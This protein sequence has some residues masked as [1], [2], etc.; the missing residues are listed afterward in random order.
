L[1]KI[2]AIFL[3]C[4]LTLLAPGQAYVHAAR[5]V[6]PKVSGAGAARGFPVGGNVAGASLT[7][8]QLLSPNL[9]V[10]LTSVL[11][12]AAV[13][14]AFAPNLS[15]PV[16]SS[17]LRNAPAATSLAPL[18]P[19]AALTSGQPGA[20]ALTAV[21]GG[22]ARNSTALTPRKFTTPARQPRR[23]AVLLRGLNLPSVV[24]KGAL[25]SSAGAKD[26]GAQD[27]ARRMGGNYQSQ[28]TASPVARQA[29]ISGAAS[30]NGL[31][32]YAAV[33]PQ[34]LGLQATRLDALPG[35]R[36]GDL[37][38]HIPDAAPLT[39][40]INAVIPGDRVAATSVESLSSPYPQAT[41]RAKPSS[42]WA[43]ILRSLG[44]AGTAVGGLFKAH[45]QPVFD[46]VADYRD[47]Q[48]VTEAPKDAEHSSLYFPLV[49]LG[50]SA[51]LMGL[52]VGV[53]LLFEYVLPSVLSQS[54]MDTVIG[55]PGAGVIAAMASGAFWGLAAVTIFSGLY[56]LWELFAF[57][58]GII[59]KDAPSDDEFWSFLQKELRA[60]NLHPSVYTS[61]LGTGPGRGLL[62]IYRP[63]SK[64]GKFSFA[65]TSNGAV[66][67]RPELIRTP[68]LL[69]MVLKHEFVHL[70]AHLKRGPPQRT[71]LRGILGFFTGEL[72][73]R[74]GPLRTQKTLENMR[75]P[76]LSRVLHEAHFSLNL[77]REYDVL[78]LK[79]G[80]H[81]TR[82]PSIYK[83]LS[84]EQATIDYLPE[85]QDL[86]SYLGQKDNQ[87]RFRVV[88]YPQAFDALP[89]RGTTEARRLRLALLRLDK[90][91]R[92]ARQ[93]PF[94]ERNRT[95]GTSPEMGQI[96]EL[97]ARLGVKLKANMSTEQLEQLIE[98]MFFRVSRESLA[99]IPFVSEL[100]RLY[101][102]LHHK[103]A[104]MMPF[105]PEEPGLDVIERVMR[106]WQSADGGGFAVQRVDLPEGGHILVARK[107]EP[108]V[109][110]WLR[111]AA[112]HEIAT[113]RTNV[114][115]RCEGGS[116]AVNVLR[117]AGFTDS[118]LERFVDADMEVRHI[119]GNDVGD[120]R[121]YV[122]VKRSRAKALRS[123]AQESGIKFQS[124]RAGYEL[125]LIKTAKMHS[126]Q[127]AWRLQITGE[128]G[129]IYDIDTG[130]D[131]EHPDFADR[132]L[133][134]VDFVNE[135]PEDWVGHGTHKGGI[136]YANG[137]IYRG[138][139]PG[140]EGRMGKVFAQTGAGASDGDIMA[141]AVDAMQW[142]ADVISLSLGSPGAVDSPLAQF[143]SR[144]TRQ[145]NSKGEYPIV[146]G[147]AG[148][149][150][151][152][153]QSKSQPSVGEYVASIAAANKAGVVSFFSSVGPALDRRWGRKRYRRPF[154]ATAVGGDVT[155][156][157]DML[158]RPPEKRDVYEGGVEAPKSRNMAPSPSDTADGKHTRM[159]GTSMSNPVYA[160][161]A[162]LVKQAVQRVVKTGSEAHEFFMQHLPDA[163][164]LILM[165]SSEDMR[166][167]LYFQ[168][169][170]FINAE[171]AI[172]MGARTFGGRLMNWRQRAWSWLTFWRGWFSRASEDGKPWE[173]IG[174]A[175]AVWAL[176][177]RV[178]Q[179]AE[180]ARAKRIAELEAN[181]TDGPQDAPAEHP[182]QYRAAKREMG[183]AA[184][185]AL[186][187]RF[188]AVRTE[189]TPE[190]TAT[191]AFAE[192]G[193]PVEPVWLV[194]MYAAWA[195]LNLKTP[196]AILPLAETALND[197]DGR[198]RQAA[199]LAIAET[200]S[201]GA[202]TALRQALT[203]AR[204]DVRMYAGYALAR[205]G[206]ASGVPAILA[207]TKSFDERIRHTAVWLL[208]QLGRRAP[209]EATDSLSSRVMDEEEQGNIRHLGV[210]SLTEI[211]AAQP[212]SVTNETILQLLH[213]AGPRNFAL[214][215][216]IS[217]FFRQAAGSAEIRSRM[218]EKPLRDDIRSF[219]EKYKSS[220]LRPGAL[221]D[222]V[223]IFA[224]VL[225]VPLDQPTPLPNPE[226]VGIV[227]VDP[228]LGPVHMIV[229]VPAVEEGGP[230]IQRYQDFRSAQG[231]AE[232]TQSLASF[233]LNADMI[234]RHEA[235]LQVAMPSSQALWFNVPDHKVTAFRT[236]MES[237]GYVVRRAGP[238][239]RLVHETGPLT[240]MPAVR[241]ELGLTGKN[242]TVAYLDEGGAT[243]HPAIAA[244]RIKG[245]KNFSGDG[246]ADQVDKEAV[247]HGTHGMGIVGGA[248]F[249]GKDGPSPY[250]GMAPEVDFLIG[251]VMGETG[252]SEATVMAGMEWAAAQIEDP[253]KTPLILNM[254]LGGPGSPDSPLGRLAN[255][256]RLNN[257]AVI[258]AAGNAGPRE[259]TVSSPANAALATAIGAVDKA[260][261]LTEYSSRSPSGVQEVNRVNYGGAVNFDIPNMYEIVSALNPRLSDAMAEQPTGIKFDG[262]MLFHTMSGTSMAAPHETGH[263]ALF[264]ERMMQV[265]ET[266]PDGYDLWLDGLL[267]RTAEK[268]DHP[269]NEVG[270]GRTDP[271]AALAALNKALEAPDTI[272]TE[273]AAL[274]AQ[275]VTQH[276]NPAGPA[277]PSPGRFRR[278]HS[279]LPG[280]LHSW[281]VAI[282]S[283]GLYPW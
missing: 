231:R 160:G 163:V 227:G 263:R 122:N 29:A 119:F 253:L 148:N 140:A 179:E 19:V 229:E 257:I 110:L 3:T 90:V 53:P 10:S 188:N 239:Y 166:V 87:R 223:R 54:T 162:L 72:G 102:S 121:I 220:V 20:A 51:G 180:V 137:T 189:V 278:L 94:L 142:G 18:V 221:G 204:A 129:R 79:P 80:S 177:D 133:E 93:L 186:E 4:A 199:F 210:A 108:R 268:L 167:P 97:A 261:S 61:L 77:G 274:K 103:G 250:V 6:A 198:V 58:V 99:E 32:P 70:R 24:T 248:S 271:E 23:N 234:G 104:V 275:A 14:G 184:N 222:M 193:T 114:T 8:P 44:Q 25:G 178:Y 233:G 269:A 47:A 26:A 62:K 98:D 138:I 191:L 195:L 84:D 45:S 152:F 33:T 11:P 65:F 64:Y 143:F 132:A 76:V 151:P 69:R 36:S 106:Y 50:L 95:S 31:A 246:H 238:M 156:P 113:S 88:V 49:L 81:E 215:R 205:H 28:R 200:Q 247:S 165:R 30:V 242:V 68:W 73:A 111:P 249:A 256:L 75:I 241:K 214:T 15:L 181:R 17:L 21:P 270:A 63:S 283:L 228:K 168:E 56:L 173:W 237:Q 55:F 67:L 128:G 91:Y 194:R 112:G 125:H 136:S 66:Y 157:P 251:K 86:R 171:S 218:R 267:D 174:R 260:G 154:G 1:R 83:D 60:W 131:T 127:A 159:S 225:N 115:S 2:I 209:P 280:T 96:E 281:L 232:R 78:M 105:A 9:N 150:G 277:V 71:G 89:G 262:K 38:I 176:E 170:G 134:S 276:G 126:A 235:A 164:N 82:N 175:K 279:S 101:E 226:G 161:A 213:T 92:L 34:A 124:S 57:Y 147:S 149:S 282:M 197:P 123:Y 118:D 59:T 243:N 22:F 202:D 236:E 258:T 224:R 135:G 48:T 13:P 183:D 41:A 85:G 16:A 172:H 265:F 254:S 153:G 266:L 39:L 252:G 155:T 272:V 27:F 37:T 107:D 12:Q 196:T 158:E 211:A 117:E 141:A 116:C 40:K 192:D 208:G 206:D 219:I 100:E 43:P 217:K 187:R 190:L 7:G 212:S 240:G 169:G 244:S 120:N 146:T 245:K 182:E 144:L 230:S 74:L 52:I 139:A 259:G 216:T 42:R 185:I 35:K 264:I 145:K 5:I 207:E 273:S 255:K 203:D 130:L 109:D 201:Y 46:T